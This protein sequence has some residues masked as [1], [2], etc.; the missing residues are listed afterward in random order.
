MSSWLSCGYEV[1][2]FP[3]GRSS[4]NIIGATA[5]NFT[6]SSTFSCFSVTYVV[7]FTLSILVTL[8]NSHLSGLA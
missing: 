7:S 6:T 5:F 4:T 3:F 1:Q 8:I 2:K